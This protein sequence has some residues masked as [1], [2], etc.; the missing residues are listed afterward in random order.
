M[1][2]FVVCRSCG[3]RIKAGRAFCLKCFEPLPDP[4]A[5][6]PTTMWDSLGW[7]PVQQATLV[8]VAALVVIGLVV[9][10]W[11]TLPAPIEDAARP[12]ARP[13]D[14]VAQTSAPPASASTLPAAGLNAARVEPFV[15]TPLAPAPARAEP[16]DMQTLEASRAAYDQQITQRPGDADL[17]ERKGRILEAMG[18]LGEAVTTFER[19]AVLSP[20]TRS[21]HSDLARVYAALGQ[22]DR[23]I[24]EYREVVRLQPDDYAGRYTLAM[25]LQRRGE[26]EAA[27]P[28]F[29]KAVALGPAEPAAHL[30]LGVSLERVGRLAEAVPEY[31]RYIAMQPSSADSERLK[32][33]LAAVGARA[34]VK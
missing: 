9:F 29:Q 15:P 25:S 28:E 6:E 10:I 27:I 8:I 30:A 21:Y 24:T 4:E 26:D 20:E 33:H 19:A 1:S 3:T 22:A 18:R 31:E 23:A 34:Q 14:S 13:A 16:S 5:A 17:L 12:V 7:S 32:L 11:Q 2:G